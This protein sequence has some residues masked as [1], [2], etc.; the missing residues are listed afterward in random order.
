MPDRFVN[1]MRAEWLANSGFC[2]V[3]KVSAINPDGSSGFV[4]VSRYISKYIAKPKDICPWIAQRLVE[5]PRRLSSRNFGTHKDYIDQIKSYYRCEKMNLPS[6]DARLDRI[7]ER[8]KTLTLDGVKFPFPRRVKEKLFYIKKKEEDGTYRLEK[9]ALQDLVVARQRV[10]VVEDF[11]GQLRAHPLYVADEVHHLASLAVGDRESALLAGRE[12][13]A[14]K[15]LM[16]KLS[17]DIF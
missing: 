1:F 16:R 6:P 8:T 5:A 7:I 13:R 12:D 3:K 2:D 17:E 14:Q 4:K 11:N 15:N 10:R 9:S